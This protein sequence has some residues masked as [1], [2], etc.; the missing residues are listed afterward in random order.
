MGHNFA[1]ILFFIAA[2]FNWMVGASLFFVPS[3]FLNFFSIDQNLQQVLWMDLFAGLVF[4]FGIG[5]FWVYQ[6]PTTN[7]SIIRLGIIGK[8][9]VILIAS[10]HV[11]MDEI[12]WQFLLPVSI[13]LVFIIL[14]IGALN[15]FQSEDRTKL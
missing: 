12:N 3:A 4:V 6:N 14:F 9:S 10:Y 15:A 5:Y 8:S 7:L 13:D 1:N 2:L 11:I